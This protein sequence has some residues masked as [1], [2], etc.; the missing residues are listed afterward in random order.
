MQPLRE[1]SGSLHPEARA[2]LEQ[3]A[4]AGVPSY[5]EGGILGARRVVDGAR[6]FQPDRAPVAAVWDIL[7]AGAAG[8]LPA[9]VY[10]PEP[11]TALPMVL[12]LHGGGFVAGG[13][14]VA[15]RP[16]RSLARAAHCVIVSIEYRLAPEDPFPAAVLDTVAAV[17][18]LVDHA[19]AI[20]AD[21]R[22]LV[23]VGDSAG[24]TIAASAAH[25]LR[26]TQ[27][28]AGQVLIYPTLVPTREYDSA[29]LDENGEGYLMTRASLEWF[30]DHYLGAPNP[31]AAG[32]AVAAAPL[33]AG[34]VSGMPP[35]TI[36]VAQFDPLRDEGHAYAERLEA[37]GVTASV[38]EIA[39][40]I[41]G[42]WWMPG[43]FTA[44]D[45]LTASIGDRLRALCAG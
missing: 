10:H 29:S 37:A 18:W 20:G 12:Y 26:G 45:E 16:C 3:A 13:V 36:Y 25:A 41:H 1:L 33:L 6:R 31:E 44:A 30:W 7:V 23:L 34:D 27:P 9:R 43:V 4:A 24:G 5:E 42:F 2:F 28:L 8:R 35:T 11:G 39:G 40:A 32:S 21:A 38:D 17:G 14:A 22:R 15:D 19:A